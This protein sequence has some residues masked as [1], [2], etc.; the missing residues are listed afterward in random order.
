MV[1]KSIFVFK[2]V[3]MDDISRSAA[4]RR[5][6]DIEDMIT[7]ENDENKRINL[8][9]L[10]AINQSSI[11]NTEL[12]QSLVLRLEKQENAFDK[13]VKEGDRFLYFGKGV[14]TVLSAVLTIVQS[15]IVYGLITLNSQLSELHAVD[16][17]TAT[18]LAAIRGEIRTITLIAGPSGATGAA[19]PSGATGAKGATGATG[20]FFGK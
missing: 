11:V 13:H 20:S 1:L 9:V 18:E 15:L 12:A 19:G 16:I 6:A 3:L 8:V 7:K 14:W 5:T 17:A 4:E 2:G 10:N